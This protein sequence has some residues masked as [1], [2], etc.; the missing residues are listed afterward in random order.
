VATGFVGFWKKTKGAKE[1]PAGVAQNCTG[2]IE[3]E[4][5]LGLLG[6]LNTYYVTRK[7][8]DTGK[9]RK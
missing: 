8:E 6:T 9:K 3:G 5:G 7:G 2:T 4:G 1:S